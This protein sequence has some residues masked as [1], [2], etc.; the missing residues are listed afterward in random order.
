[1]HWKLLSDQPKAITIKGRKF[2]YCSIQVIV[3]SSLLP[4]LTY[5][6]GMLIVEFGLYTVVS[7]L[8]NANKKKKP[9]PK[10]L[11]PRSLKH[12]SLILNM[13]RVEEGENRIGRRDT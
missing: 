5:E 10:S 1:M 8:V 4:A 2:H 13:S 9:S 3:S 6:N 7:L 12:L 11:G